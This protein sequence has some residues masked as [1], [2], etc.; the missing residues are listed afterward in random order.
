MERLFRVEAWTLDRSRLEPLSGAVPPFSSSLNLGK[1][2][3]NT[4]DLSFSC[5]KMSS[6]DMM[7]LNIP[8]PPTFR[9]GWWSYLIVHLPFSLTA[10]V[11]TLCASRGCLFCRH[12]KGP[13]NHHLPLISKQCHFWTTSPAPRARWNITQTS[14]TSA[15]YICPFRS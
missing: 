4:P 13:T 6:L 12:H 3:L 11:A 5:C 2:H 1:N 9:A 7:T 8:S 14:L 10:V 15:F